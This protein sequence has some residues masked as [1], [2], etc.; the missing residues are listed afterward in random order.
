M[1]RLVFAALLAVSCSHKSDDDKEGQTVPT[2]PSGPTSPA[3]PGAPGGIVEREQYM[4]FHNLKRCWHRVG[5]IKWS[6]RL[7]D[8]ARAHA[9]KCT[10]K[11]DPAIFG[12]LGEN[13]AHGKVLG[14]IKAQDNWYLPFIYYPYGDKNGTPATAEFSQ[15]VWRETV[16]LG[17]GSAKC[18]D[19]NY[20]VCRYSPAGNVA[21]KYDTNVYSLDPGFMKCTGMPRK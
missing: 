8:G 4:V 17:C 9:A 12:S 15:I 13:I 21:G 2:A 3:N 19:E 14:Q 18:G 5:D 11:K 7:A 10:L 1:R 16:E 6:E 20:Y